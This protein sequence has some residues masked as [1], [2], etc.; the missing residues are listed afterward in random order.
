M[1]KSTI[2]S[3]SGIENYLFKTITIDEETKI[4]HFHTEI[5]DVDGE[6]G[7]INNLLFDLLNCK[8]TKNVEVLYSGGMDSELVLKSCLL[9]KIPTTALTLRL[10][11]K[12]YPINLCDLYY[13]EKFCRENSVKQT[14]IDLDLISFLEKGEHLKYLLPYKIPTLH[15][16][17]HFYLFEQSTGFPVMGGEYSWPWHHKPLISPHKYQYS[18]YDKFLQDK[19]IH[20]IG[21]A[22][23]ASLSINLTMIKN[24]LD[25]MSSK[26]YNGDDENI[27]LF[28]KAL[29][30]KLELGNFELRKKSYG[31]EDIGLTI[32][33]KRKVYSEELINQ[34]GTFTHSISWGNKIANLIGENNDRYNNQFV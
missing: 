25:V 33:Q 15:V 31:W 29:F 16:A 17:S 6:V 9:N 12:G 27:P 8:Q 2:T 30:E 5:K 22:L 14:L 23:S 7:N 34:T 32:F 26:N 4:H 28:K 20:G 24:H 13:S 18:M 10:L 1:A 19:G 3:Y 11:Y 21:N